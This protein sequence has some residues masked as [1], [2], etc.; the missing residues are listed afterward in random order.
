MLEPTESQNWGVLKPGTCLWTSMSFNT[1]HAAASCSTLMVPDLWAW[2]SKLQSSTEMPTA[3]GEQIWV[4]EQSIR[5]LV[6]WSQ[7]MPACF[8][9]RGVDQSIKGLST[10]SKWKPN[11]M[12]TSCRN[13]VTVKSILTARSLV[14]IEISTVLPLERNFCSSPCSKMA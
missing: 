4:V 13:G 1:A 6:T 7:L 8:G 2:W 5:G 3:I 11:I 14:T 10:W 9:K 12:S